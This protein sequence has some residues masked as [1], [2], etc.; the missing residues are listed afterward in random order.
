[1]KKSLFPILIAALALPLGAHSE[2]VL[3]RERGLSQTE[4]AA[5]GEVLHEVAGSRS[6]AADA[7]ANAPARRYSPDY[8]RAYP[9]RMQAPG[10]AKRVATAATPAPKPLAAAKPLPIAKPTPAPIKPRVV[11]VQKVAALPPPKKARVPATPTP[12]P[13]KPGAA[14]RV[15][16]LPPAAKARI[17][18]TPTP[19]PAKPAA[20]R[21]VAVAAP[22]VKA[23]PAPAPVVKVK[24]TPKPVVAATPGVTPQR[25]LML[26]PG[27]KSRVIITKVPPT[28][29]PPIA[30]AP[31]AKKR[32]GGEPTPPP[33]TGRPPVRTVFPEPN[34]R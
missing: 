22:T 13:V 15:A 7:A 3:A 12:T 34:R 9:R 25:V 29:P 4:S 26:P 18:A 31:T 23:N 33:T 14:R 28:T 24:P 10:T 1:M 17:L 30:P 8:Y 2:G 11:A 21:R 19:A 27:T 32:K 16:V 6:N 20:P 5:A